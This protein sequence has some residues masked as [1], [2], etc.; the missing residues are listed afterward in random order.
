[1][2]IYFLFKRSLIQTMPDAITDDYKYCMEQLTAIQKGRLSPFEVPA[3][4]GWFKGSKSE[5]DMA[6][7]RLTLATTNV[8]RYDRYYI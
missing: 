3:N 4:P 1:L 2:A 7:S 5:T 8:V 6:R